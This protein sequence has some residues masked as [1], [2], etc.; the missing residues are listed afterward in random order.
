VTSRKN[1]FDFRRA[2]MAMS[3]VGLYHGLW[4]SVTPSK[5]NNVTTTYMKMIFALGLI[6]IMTQPAKYHHYG[7]S[8]FVTF[9][10]V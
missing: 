3:G 4:V 6:V 9:K 10:I 7:T 2:T 8:F 1:Y 5:H